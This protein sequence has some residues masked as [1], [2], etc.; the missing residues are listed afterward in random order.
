MAEGKDREQRRQAERHQQADKERGQKRHPCGRIRA[1]AVR[2]KQGDQS[3]GDSRNRYP[4]PGS[5]MAK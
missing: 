5:L 4:K 3:D 1:V 2:H